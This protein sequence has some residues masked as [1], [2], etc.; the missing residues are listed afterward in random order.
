MPEPATIRID[1][2]RYRPEQEDRPVWQ[3]YVV[4]YTRDMSVLQ[5]LQ[6]IK[7]EQDGTLSFRW[8]CRMAICGSCAMMVNGKPALSCKTFLRDLEPGPVKVEA[9]AHFP[10]ERDLVVSVDEFV[11]KLESIK[12]YLIPKAPRALDEGEYLQTPAELERFEQFASCI[13]CMLCY[14]ACPQ[15]G[16]DA[17]FIGPGVL[18]LLHRYNADSRD[19]GRAERMPILNA[20]E[21]V[22]SCTAVGYC[23]EVCPKHVDPANAVNQNKVNSAKDYFLRFLSPRRGKA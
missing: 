13:N 18:A 12:P 11:G 3:S 8:S 4:S 10:I 15:Y 6:Q 7:D 23:S 17:S 9:L 21:G 20:E 14:A 2:L 1:V 16:L 19:G 22:W 5:G